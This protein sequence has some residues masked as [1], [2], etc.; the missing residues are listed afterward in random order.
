V[1]GLAVGTLVSVAPLLV[2]ELSPG[3]FPAGAHDGLAATPLAIV[4]VA[5]VVHQVVR[6]A[7]PLELVK[8]SVLALGFLFWAANQL[9]PDAP[10]ATLY[11]DLA[12]AA[13]VLDAVLTMVGWPRSA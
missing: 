4:A 10:R 3:L 2:W 7:L 5:F 12:I 1:N 13:F 11:D 8:A 9:W 6:G